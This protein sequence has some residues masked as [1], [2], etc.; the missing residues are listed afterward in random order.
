MNLRDDH[1]HLLAKIETEWNRAEAD[2]KTAEHVVANI[3][4]PSVKE[5]RY[6]GRRLVEALH[7][8]NTTPEDARTITSL[9]DDACFN[10]YR[11]RHD[12]V[13]AT[14]AKIALDID[15]MV[16]KLGYDSI[17]P[18][19]PSFPKLF[20]EL[21]SVR[22]KIV[23]SRGRREDRE[24]IYSVLESIDFP[25]LVNSFNEMRASEDMMKALAKKSR[26]SEFFGRWALYIGIASLI[27]AVA[28]RIF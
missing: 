11:A 27:I 12:A 21:Q 24:A 6:A 16:S 23:E 9:L 2:I 5:L 25:A 18:A 28:L 8:I 20:R 17:L 4:I 26:R 1:I 10:C 7:L 3:V 22:A 19:F 13:D 14:T 15:T